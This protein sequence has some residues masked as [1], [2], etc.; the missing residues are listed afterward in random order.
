MA[1]SV[2][3]PE[4]GTDGPHHAHQTLR[5]DATRHDVSGQ[6]IKRNRKKNL[7]VQGIP[8]IEDDAGQDTIPEDEVRIRCDHAQ[9]HQQILTQHEQRHDQ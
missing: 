9:H 2:T 4:P 7:L 6:N 5:H 8:G 3:V 1:S